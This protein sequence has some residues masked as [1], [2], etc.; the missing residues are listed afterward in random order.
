MRFLTIV[1]S[2]EHLGAPPQALM[3]AMGRLAEEAFGTGAM[4]DTAGLY[5]SATGTR[6]RVSNGTLA[7]TDGPFTESKELIG[8]YAIFEVASKEEMLEWTRRFMELHREHWPAWEGETEIR[9][10]YVP[11]DASTGAMRH[12]ACAAES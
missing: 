7:T 9:Q 11:L 8:G 1:K 6:V 3:E 10:I 12:D 5:P 4:V 2:P